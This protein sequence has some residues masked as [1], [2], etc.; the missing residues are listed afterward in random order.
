MPDVILISGSPSATS[1]SVAILRATAEALEQRGLSTEVVSVRDFP[2]EDL[3]FGR[4][5]SP[6]FAQAK[7]DL[8]AAAGVVVSTPIYKASYTAALKGFLDILPQSALRGKVVLPLAT[9]GTL[10]HL[11]AIDYALKPVLSVLGATEIHQGVY[12]TD[13]QVRV[14]PDGALTM[15]DELRARHDAAVEQFATAVEARRTTGSA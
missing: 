13:E 8:A 3:I 2:A 1:R 10:A 15:H 14:T 7:Q 4:W 9:G 5:D 6:A 11:L 12:S